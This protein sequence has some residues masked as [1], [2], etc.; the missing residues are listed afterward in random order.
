[1][2]NTHLSLQ[3]TG[4]CGIV[5]KAPIDQGANQATLLLVDATAPPAGGPMPMIGPPHEPHV[6]VLVCNAS[7]VAAGSR[8]PSVTFDLQGISLSIFYLVDQELI[9]KGS[10]SS[11][12][13]FTNDAGSGNGCQ[14]PNPDYKNCNWIVSL[15]TISPGPT[16][17]SGVV[18]PACLGDLGTPIDPIVLSRIRLTEGTMSTNALAKDTGGGILKWNFRVP[19]GAATGRQQALAEVVEFSRDLG[20]AITVTFEAALLRS[21]NYDAIQRL[22]NAG[23]TAI[24]L[25]DIGTNVIEAS[26]RNIPWPDLFGLR[27]IPPKNSRL[28]DTH[29]DHFYEMSNP[30]VR[31][32]RNIPDPLAGPSDPRCPGVGGPGPNNPQCPPALF[33]PNPKA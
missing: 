23:N 33:D 27:P 20:S 30:P 6:P 26:I 31:W 28:M 29:F 8:P 25:K 15:S 11:A 7:S 1:M 24:I 32:D 18:K 13:T 19:G 22:F 12:L 9:I 21:T 2:A 10:A 3:F 14:G 4:L 16:P 17:G 5:P